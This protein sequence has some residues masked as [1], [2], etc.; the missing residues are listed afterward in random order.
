MVSL[1]DSEGDINDNEKDG[2]QV[3]EILLPDSGDDIA[4]EDDVQVTEIPLPDE[5]TP[6]VTDVAPSES[7]LPEV[8]SRGSELNEYENET[9]Y[10]DEINDG[11]EFHTQSPDPV[12][13]GRLSPIPEQTESEGSHGDNIPVSDQDE[14]IEPGDESQ[15][16]SQTTGLQEQESQM[17]SEDLTAPGMPADSSTTQPGPESF[18][19]LYFTSDRTKL[20]TLPGKLRSF[21]LRPHVS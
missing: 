7:H 9:G 14:P 11:N 2:V 10:E 6:A 18:P 4:E 1:P 12:D 3:T 16:D 17:V 8:L 5:A 13:D 21:P 19:P 20:V 15:T